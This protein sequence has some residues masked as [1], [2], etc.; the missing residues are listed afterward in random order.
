[1]LEV[2]KLTE[3]EPKKAASMKEEQVVRVKITGLKE[4]GTVKSVKC[5]E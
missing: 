1:M 4:D 5:V 3:K 2:L